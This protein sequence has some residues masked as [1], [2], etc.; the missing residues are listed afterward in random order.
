MHLFFEFWGLKMPAYGFMIAMG[1]IIANCIAVFVLKRLKLDFNDLIILEGYC[2]LGAYLGS[3]SLY[4]I[5]S[6]KII[7][8][9]RIL[10]PV[11]LNEIMKTGFVFYGGLILGSLFV[12]AAGKFHNI[13]SMLYARKFIFL[14]PIMHAFGR[15]GCF[16]AGCCYGIPYDGIGAV[17]FP[18]N[19]YAI[20]NVKLFPVQLLELVLLLLVAIVI[21]YL[22]IKR[23]WK[24]TIETYLMLYAII[25][26]MLEYVR[27]DA[28]RGRFGI[29][30]TSQWISI[31]MIAVA[32]FMVLYDRK[33]LENE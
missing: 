26:F 33:I 23:E 29:F 1:V 24:Y 12:L 16:F 3:K 10:D 31:F 11:Y 4:L 21:L 14:V 27:Y 25:R 9:N 20:P 32:I 8:W 7:E 2:I 13:N 28:A 18:D 15:L 30:S 17:V 22:Q 5:V 6:Y 19:C